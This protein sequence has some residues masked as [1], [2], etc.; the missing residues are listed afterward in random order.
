[1]K[2]FTWSAFW[3][4]VVTIVALGVLAP[5]PAAAVANEPQLTR[6]V[7]MD[8]LAQHAT[9]S[10]CWMAIRGK[11]YDF[12]DYI[13]EHPTPPFIMVQWCG[14]EATEAYDTKGYGR[15]H[16]AMADAMLERYFVG[17][18]ITD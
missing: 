9:E 11:V 8:E 6:E 10:D 18:L 7:T 13:P 12:T 1:M 17:I 14:K 2:R 3:A 4:S 5:E 15:P 16:S